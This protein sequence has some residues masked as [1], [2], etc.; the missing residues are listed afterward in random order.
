[1][2]FSTVKIRIPLLPQSLWGRKFLLCWNNLPYLPCLPQFTLACA[3]IRVCLNWTSVRPWR[4]SLLGKRNCINVILSGRNCE[5]IVDV[6]K[7]ST[8]DFLH[9]PTLTCKYT[10]MFLQIY[11]HTFYTLV[12]F[13]L[14]Q[15][16]L[17]I[18]IYSKH[19]KNVVSD[20]TSFMSHFPTWHCAVGLPSSYSCVD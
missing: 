5:L 10:R 17:R 19:M 16:L 18:D 4:W 15:Q 13:I 1:M 2:V 7:G 20:I 12:R 8:L 3:K 14:L 11:S 9:P 6:L